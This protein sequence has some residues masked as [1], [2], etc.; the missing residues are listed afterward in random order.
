MKKYFLILIVLL[1]SQASY[2]QS[3]VLETIYL[4][5]GSIIKG[6]IVEIVPNSSYT[7]KTSDGSTIVCNSADILKITRELVEKTPQASGNSNY[8]LMQKGANGFL[9]KDAEIET[10]VDAIYMVTEKGNY[11]TEAVAEA[12]AKG[13]ISS[14]KNKASTPNRTL[15]S[16]GSINSSS[17]NSNIRPE[18]LDNVNIS[19]TLVVILFLDNESNIFKNVYPEIKE[20]IKVALSD[21]DA[22]LGQ[23]KKNE[24][25]N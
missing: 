16:D 23:Y 3:N 13:A 15:N 12:L 2:S 22:K 21:L 5:N 24:Q 8:K 11:F 17:G 4:K 20:D 9:P 1:W 25:D 14:E 10:I 7:I 6:M 19:R 18:I